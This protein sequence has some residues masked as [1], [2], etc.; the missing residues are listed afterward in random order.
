MDLIF[1]SSLVL[2]LPLYNLDGASFMSRDAYGHRCTVTGAVW[3]LNGC[4]FDETDDRITVGAAGDAE[5][6][7]LTDTTIL[8]WAC[9]SSLASEN[10]SIISKNNRAGED[11]YNLLIQTTGAPQFFYENNNN[12]VS[13]TGSAGVVTVNSWYFFSCRFGNGGVKLET[14]LGDQVTNADTNVM[15]SE[16][17][18][19][20]PLYIGRD[21]NND[22]E[23][24]GV[25]G[26][27]FIYNRCLTNGEIQQNYLA[28]K[29][30]YR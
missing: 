12:V 4:R 21:Y 24:G 15:R 1:D 8:V 29:G 30:R 28:T 26:E 11:R 20:K 6:A 25:V 13:V 22:F 16:D 9:P 27:V 5:L 2:Y 23:F 17:G 7:G 19:A 14:N 18:T 10:K 3:R